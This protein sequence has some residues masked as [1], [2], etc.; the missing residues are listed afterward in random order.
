MP[1][2]KQ[3]AII[4]C[5]TRGLLADLPIEKVRQFEEEY[6]DLLELKHK[7]LLKDLKEGKLNDNIEKQLTAVAEEIIE[8]QK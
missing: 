4:F 5:G 2:E 6:L 8:K 3:I 7:D 1:V